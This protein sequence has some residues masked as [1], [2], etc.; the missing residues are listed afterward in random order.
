M[1]VNKVTYSDKHVY[2]TFS[3]LYVTLLAFHGFYTSTCMTKVAHRSVG[4]HGSAVNSMPHF[5]SVAPII[6]IRIRI[7]IIT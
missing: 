4:K 6:D 1:I 7:R 3:D 5:A 2:F